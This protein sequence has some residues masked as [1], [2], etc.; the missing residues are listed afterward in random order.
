MASGPSGP[1]ESAERALLRRWVREGAVWWP[2]HP[3][4]ETLWFSEGP[5]D[6]LTDDENALLKGLVEP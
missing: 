4:D 1:S 6:N 5:D 2:D 3:L